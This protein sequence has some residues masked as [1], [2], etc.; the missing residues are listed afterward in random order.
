VFA[1]EWLYGA[2]IA[3]REV[4]HH[5]ATAQAEKEVEEVVER[6]PIRQLEA[7]LDEA[8]LVI[9]G[10]VESIEPSPIPDGFSLHSPNYRLAVVRVGSVLKGKAGE[11]VKFCSQPIPLLV[12]NRAATQ[13]RPKCCVY[14]AS[15]DGPKSSSRV[16]HSAR[17]AR[18]AIA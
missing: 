14:P 17:S 8:V 4:A 2:Q 6:L 16:F 10:E 1:N 13:R 18:C 3:L 12:A 5:K 9:E 11:R 15:R 7:R